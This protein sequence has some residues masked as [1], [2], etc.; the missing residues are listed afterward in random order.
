MLIYLLAYYLLGATILGDLERMA[1]F[2]SDNM[3]T[4][5]SA[6]SNYLH[7]RVQWYSQIFSLKWYLWQIL[8][9][10]ILANFRVAF[11]QI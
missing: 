7:F 1:C 9:E 3:Q 11:Y 4:R 10:G 6:L 8:N 2:S 5:I